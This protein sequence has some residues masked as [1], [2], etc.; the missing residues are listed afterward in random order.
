MLLNSFDDSDFG[1]VQLK[2]NPKA[3][4]VIFR[5]AGEYLHIT[6]PPH[7]SQKELL[8]ILEKHRDVLLQKKQKVKPPTPL[9]EATVLKTMGFAVSIFRTDRADFYFSRKDGVLHIACPRHTDFDKPTVRAL[10][11]K[12]IERYLKSDAKRYLPGRLEALAREHALTFSEVKI[13]SSKTR[14]GSCSGRKSI[15]LSFYLMLLP[16]HL[17]DYVLLHE[18]THTLEM[19]HSPRFWAKLN[20]FSGQR[21][22]TLKSELR[23]Y[24]TSL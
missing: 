18:L 5:F 12:G 15:N 21:S 2:V 6:V 22:Q 13:N 24:R 10:L 7:C 20:Q 16:A 14:W 11:V 3:R 8:A 17:I 19:N 1:E 4:N 9:N 23:H